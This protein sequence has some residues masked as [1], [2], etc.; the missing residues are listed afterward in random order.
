MKRLKPAVELDGA[1][2]GREVSCGVFKGLFEAA[3]EDDVDLEALVEG[4]GFPLAHFLNPTERV[5]WTA[6]QSVSER[7]GE[8]WSEAELR[9]IGARSLD[10]QHFEPQLFLARL[11]LRPTE[12]YAFIIRGDTQ[13]D[14]ACLSAVT[15]VRNLDVDIEITINRGYGHAPALF[16]IMCGAAEV[17]PKIFGLPPA[18]VQLSFH[19]R[20]AHLSVQVPP[21]GGRW[22]WFERLRNRVWR[23]HGLD[24]VGDR[25]T[26]RTMAVET[27]VAKRLTVESDLKAALNEHQRRLANLND[28]VIELDLDGTVTFVSSNIERVLQINEKDFVGDPWNFLRPPKP[29]ASSPWMT[30]VDGTSRWIEVNPSRSSDD[31]SS[32]FLLVVRDVT[33]RVELSEQLSGAMRLESLGVMAAGV[34][35]DFNNLLVPIATNAGSILS[36][37][38]EGS[39]IRDRALAIEQAARMASHLTDQIL[40]TTGRSIPSDETCDVGRVVRSMRPVLVDVVPEHVELVFDVAASAPAQVDEE[41]LSKLLTN[42]V[43]NAGQAIEGSGTVTVSVAI[44]ADADAVVL[45]VVDDGVGMAPDTAARITEPFFTTRSQGRGLGLAALSGLLRS[46]TATLEV[47]TALGEGTAIGVTFRP[48][49]VPLGRTVKSVQSGWPQSDAAVLL[50][51]DDDLVRQTLGRLMERAFASVHAVADAVQAREVLADETPI[52]YVIVDL[53]MPSVR[54]PEL[55]VQLRNLRSSPLPALIITGAGVKAAREEL[56]AA[57]LVDVD[58]LTKPFSPSQLFDV[59]AAQLP[60]S[61]GS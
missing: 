22:S 60:A 35:H 9:A 13:G 48:A 33:E 42:L 14:F 34:A 45:R 30:F 23:S 10:N 52:D 49:R 57:G 18:P 5:S 36:D 43:V 12:A 40:S 46:Q 39:P 55:I 20:G 56:D 15:T 1:L 50:I 41:S 38:D 27:E 47:H 7:I 32:A 19:E 37:L 61:T 54:G 2:V 44:N 53:T 25:L 3:R 4:T 59:I 21:G 16:W 26:Q 17:V 28:V 51:D 29:E 31:G 58:V 8:R 6:L 11:L 24:A